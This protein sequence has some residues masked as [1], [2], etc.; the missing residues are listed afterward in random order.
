[1]LRSLRIANS[2][3]AALLRSARMT[4]ESR[5]DQH[6]ILAAPRK[7]LM[8]PKLRYRLSYLEGGDPAGKLVVFLHGTAGDAEHWTRFLH[9]VPAGYCHI[10]IDRPG[11]GE[12][13]PDQAVTSLAEQAA[14][15]RALVQ[16]RE[17]GPATL[18]GHSIG[19]SIAARAAIDG[20]HE[21]SSLV[22]LSGSFDPT[23]QHTQFL[24]HAIDN[25]PANILLPRRLRNANQELISIGGELEL[26]VPL[27]ARIGVPVVIMH[28]VDDDL[29]PV[30]N[31]EFFR[32]C[33]TSSKSVVV[34]LL[35]GHG[36]FVH[37]KA[38]SEIAA[39]I[40]QVASKVSLI[41][42]PT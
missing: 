3:I 17:Q 30:A 10:A 31:A 35:N 23:L 42:A 40:A 25:W 29:V 6:A 9:N 15:V 37:R 28:S 18:V 33:L 8:L 36:H 26:L 22:T 41:C 4:A 7:S 21:V 38:R 27:L 2:M 32:S 12:S 11:F 34:T 14:A 1:M 24:Q 19:A 20:P 13:G 5:A 39:A 16:A